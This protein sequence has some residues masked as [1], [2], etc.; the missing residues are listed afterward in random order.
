MCASTNGRRK[1]SGMAA[2]I[3]APTPDLTECLGHLRD[4]P[5]RLGVHR[6]LLGDAVVRDALDVP[7]PLDAELRVDRVALELRILAGGGD[8][9]G[10]PLELDEPAEL[11]VGLEQAYLEAL[12][13][14]VGRHAPAD[15]ERLVEHVECARLTSGHG[16]APADEQN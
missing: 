15:P 16:C 4:G 6:H 8:L 11:R 7:Q 12:D 13:A 2:V 1:S 3:P 5:D 9:L 14:T 10:G